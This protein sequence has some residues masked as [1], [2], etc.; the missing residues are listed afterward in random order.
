VQPCCSCP[1]QA[2]VPPANDFAV[3]RGR[4]CEVGRTCEVGRVCEVG[5]MCEVELGRGS[6]RRGR[7]SRGHDPLEAHL[8]EPTRRRCTIPLRHADPQPLSQAAFDWASFVRSP[9]GRRRA[10]ASLNRTPSRGSAQRNKTRELTKYLRC[11]APARR[12]GG[13]AARLRPAAAA[14]AA[15]AA[16]TGRLHRTSV[17]QRPADL[18]SQEPGRR[19]PVRR[20]PGTPTQLQ[21]PMPRRVHFSGSLGD[22]G[23]LG[24]SVFSDLAAA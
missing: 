2:G 4:M 21:K 19:T 3:S 23:D 22:L 14:A 17:R 8:A 13:P 12:G 10:S 15:A 5:R 16:A 11:I 7:P 20:P 1:R 9:G 6:A 24:G 18:R